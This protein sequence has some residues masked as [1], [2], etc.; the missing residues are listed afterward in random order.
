MSY[1]T[2]AIRRVLAVAQVT[3]LLLASFPP[4]AHATV[5]TLRNGMKVEGKIG[6]ISGLAQDPAKPT[7]KAGEVDVTQIVFLDDD[8]RRTFFPSKQVAALAESEPGGEERIVVPQR[9]PRTGRRIGIVGAIHRITPFDQWGRRILSMEGPQGRLDLVQGITLLTP[10]Y[11]KVECLLGKDSYIWTMYVATTS[12]PRTTLSTLLM[13][14]IDKNDPDDRLRIVNFYIQAERFKD[15]RVELE[16][17][18][19]DFPKLAGL[20][21]RVAGLHQNSA[22]RLI[23]EIQMRRKAGQLGLAYRM[24]SGFPTEGVAG[25]TL[26]QVREI[27]GEYSASKNQ[28]EKILGLLTKHLAEVK[29]AGVKKDLQVAL[30]EISARLNT[31]TLGRMAA[32][33]RLADDDKL[34]AEQKLSLAVSGWLMGSG[35]ATEN[36]AISTDL[37]QVKR[38]VRKFL[39]TKLQHEREAILEQLSGLEGSSPKYLSALLQNMPPPVITDEGQQDTLGLYEITIPGL[40]GQGDI[41]Y[42][43]QLPPE[44][45]PYRRYPCVVTLNGAGT[46]PLKQIDWWAGSFSEETKMRLGQ[47]SRRGYIVVAPKWTKE[48]QRKY[49]FTAREHSAVLFSLRDAIRRCSIDTDRVYL[50]GHSMG[51][52]AAWD[53]GISHPDLWAG[54]IP[55]VASADKYVSRYWENAR[56]LPMYFVAG[57]MDVRRLADNALDLDRYLTKAG[58]DVMIVEYKGRGHEHFQDEIQ[59]LFDWMQ[60]H[61]RD[62]F[63]RKFETVSM[64]TW[65]NY[66]WW[67]E[68]RN[69]PERSMVAPLNWPVARAKPANTEARVLEN[70]NVHVRTAAR[71]ATVWL[72]PD[73][74]DFDQRV[75]V[76]FNGKAFRN[77]VNPTAATLLE[78]VRTRGDRQHPFWAKVKVSR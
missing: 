27:L 78:D 33:L 67:L 69:F 51:G 36:L 20:K 1:F 45:D 48:H 37:I 14:Q 15:A 18:L 75:S 41:T 2:P 77:Q 74:V 76:L 39:N 53:I 31:N 59:N 5:V 49:E 16:K 6:K 57:E 32:Y 47:A 40:T 52:D 24:L 22:R 17:I 68:L 12:I 29:D 10:R 28:G 30:D 72:S 25:E 70:N 71:S 34:S 7:G 38:L 55:I 46:T 63:P 58:Y 13:A 43:V 50:S 42:Y 61:Q 3:L 26:L 11:A 62:F 21:K 73:M 44:Y 9:V 35:E 8:L 56:G 66:F 23:R 19:E 65:D 54:V 60:F 64:R 4:S